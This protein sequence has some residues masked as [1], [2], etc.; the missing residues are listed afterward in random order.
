MRR[1]PF[2][3]L[4]TIPRQAAKI[5]NK[6]DWLGGWHRPV[7]VR[8]LQRRMT[9]HKLPLWKQAWSMLLWKKCIEVTA[10]KRR[11]RI[12]R[13]VEIPEYLQ[14]QIIVRKPK[15]KRPGRGQSQWFLENR[16]KFDERDGIES[17]AE[18]G[19]PENGQTQ[20]AEQWEN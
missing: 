20:G 4:S 3:Q 9:H 6:L 1:D 5:L 14:A 11:Q 12:I 7:T 16:P 8:E 17:P 18:T 19:R 2:D 15:R 10:G 13:L